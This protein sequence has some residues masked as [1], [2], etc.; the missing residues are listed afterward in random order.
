MVIGFGKMN[1]VGDFMT[2]GEWSVS[3]LNLKKEGMSVK[4]PATY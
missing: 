4:D 3:N 1:I 2:V